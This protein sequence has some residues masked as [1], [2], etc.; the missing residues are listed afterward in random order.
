[1][2]IR[3]CKRFLAVCGLAAALFI[4][5]AHG[6]PLAWFQ[7]DQLRR[8]AQSQ[9]K[10]LKQ[11]S[12]RALQ[13]VVLRKISTDALMTSNGKE[14]NGLPRSCGTTTRKLPRSCKSMIAGILDERREP[15]GLPS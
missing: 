7:I 2:P 5:S 3:R 8:D 10:Q 4:T 1:M 14:I 6:D 15:I 13:H 11:W 9:V 12:H